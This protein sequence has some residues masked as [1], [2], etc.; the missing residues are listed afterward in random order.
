MDVK[1][2]ATHLKGRLYGTGDAR[3]C[4]R[5]P[6]VAEMVKSR[7]V[8]L[9]ILILCMLG[10]KPNALIQPRQNGNKSVTAMG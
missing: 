1:Y 4:Q 5:K 3:V 2:D 10:Q 7:H 9:G 6:F 8:H